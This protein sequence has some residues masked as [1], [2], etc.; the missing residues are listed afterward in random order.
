MKNILAFLQGKKTYI[1]VTLGILTVLAF[2]LHYITA[3]EEQTLLVL[4]GF[5]TAAA[6][7]SAINNLLNPLFDVPPTPLDVP[8]QNQTPQA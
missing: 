2:V 6:L 8:S 3:G 4:E 1:M 7:R 5:G